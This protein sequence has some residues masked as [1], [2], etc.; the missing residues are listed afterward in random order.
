MNTRFSNCRIG[1]PVS[2]F[3][4]GGRASRR[5]RSSTPRAAAD[6]GSGVGAISQMSTVDAVGSRVGSE[7]EAETVRIAESGP[8]R[9][10]EHPIYCTFLYLV[11]AGF[12]CAFPRG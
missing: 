2:G 9:A 10:H 7:L 8:V 4:E 6:G 12:V 11:A 1:A 3:G 5:S